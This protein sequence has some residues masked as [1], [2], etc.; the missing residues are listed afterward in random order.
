M[1]YLKKCEGMGVGWAES[2]Q[3]EEGEGES[4]IFLG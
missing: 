3:N 2:T 1:K 4:R